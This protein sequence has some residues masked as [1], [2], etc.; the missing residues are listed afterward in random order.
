MASMPGQSSPVSRFT[1]AT[2]VFLIVKRGNS[3]LMQRRNN[4]GHRDGLLG[5][6]SGHKEEHESLTQ[7]AIRE[8]Q[9]EIGIQL[10]PHN[11][12]L[13]GIFE[14]YSTS[15]EMLDFYFVVDQ[16]QG[17]IENQEPQKCSELCW[18]HL[19]KLPEDAIDYVR[20][21]L[22][23]IHQNNFAPNGYFEIGWEQPYE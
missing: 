8:A 6:P 16:W 22:Q 20:D 10:T 11:L 17:E 1:L 7:A 21:A 5:L 19:G 3:L 15:R 13:V 18:H 23:L 4:T 9:E 12:K 14:R 2:A